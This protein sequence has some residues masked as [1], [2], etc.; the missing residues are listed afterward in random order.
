MPKAPRTTRTTSEPSVDLARLYS[1]DE[2]AE[3]LGLTVTYVRKM[4][5]DRLIA[6][7]RVTD[8]DIRFAPADVE[9][10]LADTYRPKVNR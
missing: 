4:A 3:L 8:T 10:Y 1:A 7:Y 2:V 6:S 5:R 9:A